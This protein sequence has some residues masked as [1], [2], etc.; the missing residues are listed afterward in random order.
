[1]PTSR[2]HV[3]RRS[4]YPPNSRMMP[5][6]ARTCLSRLGRWTLTATFVPS[7]S[8]ARCTC[9][10]D[11]AASGFG[12]NSA[13]SSSGGAPSSAM[14]TSRTCSYG[15]GGTSF[16]SLSSSV[17]HSSGS[18]LAWLETICPSLTYVGPSFSIRMRVLTAGD[19]GSTGSGSW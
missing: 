9:P 2:A 6:S 14:I 12:S 5:R 8:T 19:S 15:K 10:S 16:C 18:T 1:M 3:L 7:C 4:A 11:A 13:Y 17:R